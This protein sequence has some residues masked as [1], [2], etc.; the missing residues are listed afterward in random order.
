MRATSARAKKPRAKA[1]GPSKNR[2]REQGR[3]ERA[4]EPRRL[5]P[6]EGQRRIG[7]QR[8]DDAQ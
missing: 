8:P 1:A 4:V 7:E 5:R 2:V 6:V 3:L